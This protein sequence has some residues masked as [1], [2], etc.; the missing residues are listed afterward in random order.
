MGM[1][2]TMDP[3]YERAALDAAFD[4]AKK[5]EAYAKSE[6]SLDDV[7]A[8][9]HLIEKMLKEGVPKAKSLLTESSLECVVRGQLK[10]TIACHGP[11]TANFISSATKRVTLG[12]LGHLRQASLRDLS[13]EAARLQ[14]ERLQ[15][16][17][18]DRDEKLKKKQIEIKGLLERLGIPYNEKKG[19][20]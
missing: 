11:I 16:E 14:V 4:L 13:N 15:K 12:L 19:P 8:A 9:A 1:A 5:Y 17:L 7:L 18:A 2:R 20:Q 3:E 10:T 6:G